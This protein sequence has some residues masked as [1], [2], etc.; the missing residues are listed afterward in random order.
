L[1][2]CD[3]LRSI[4]ELPLGYECCKQPEKNEFTPQQSGNLHH[5]VSNKAQREL[6]LEFAE[7]AK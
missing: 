5:G 2:R 7:A 1:R 6:S 3:Q 4:A